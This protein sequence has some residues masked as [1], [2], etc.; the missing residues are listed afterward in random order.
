MDEEKQEGILA[1]ERTK[2]YIS[3]I[4]EVKYTAECRYRI[5]DARY[6]YNALTEEQRKEITAEELKV[7]TDAE[8]EYGKLE[9][10]NEAAE[11][12]AKIDAARK[13]YDELSKEAKA[14]ITKEQ[15]KALADAESTYTKLE[16]SAENKANTLAMNS[17]FSIKTGKSIKISWGKV[18]DADGYDVYLAYCGKGKVTLVKSTKSTSVKISKLMKK[19]IDQKKDVKCYVVAYKKVNG[20]K[21][22]I[23]KSKVFHAIGKENKAVTE[24]KKIQLKKTSYVLTAGKKAT[25]KATIVKKNKK[26]PMINHT[27]KFRYATTDAKVATVSKDGKITAKKKGTCYVYVYAVN[28][29]AKKVKVT[30][31]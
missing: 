2:Q 31:K 24:P 17:K 15:Y 4:G 6:L 9:A 20:K 1:V 8:A 27:E 19:A 7:L 23:G 25:I 10:D 30:V 5:E 29:C 26:I 18:K 14:V 3:R 16:K 13:A 12:K 28:G 11:S 22:Q 21:Q